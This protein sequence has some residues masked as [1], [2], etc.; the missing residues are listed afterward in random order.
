MREKWPS[1]TQILKVWG[2][3][4]EVHHNPQEQQNF[5][6]RG[7]LVGKACNW[8]AKG[9][10]PHWG[11]PHRE[12]D[13]WINGYRRLMEDYDVVLI[14]YEV[15]LFEPGLGYIVHPDQIVLLNSV[16]A[17]LEIKTGIYN[18][19][20]TELQTAAQILAAKVAKDARWDTEHY[21]KRYCVHLPGN[22]KYSL[23]P[24]KNW[25]DCG[26]WIA[27][28]QATNVALRDDRPLGRDLKQLMEEDQRG[29]G[30]PNK[31]D[32]ADTNARTRSTNRLQSTIGSD[33]GGT[34]GGDG[35][36]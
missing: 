2:Y 9:E 26:D 24:H 8:L 33:D 12:L 14:S 20:A 5:Y 35:D 16:F 13:P 17:A 7:T 1:C 22:G 4:P 3:Y 23:I 31:K 18:A 15:R 21:L 30:K 36:T 11:K 6:D 27:L 10:E 28:V 19:R 32:R 29:T 34:D 25:R